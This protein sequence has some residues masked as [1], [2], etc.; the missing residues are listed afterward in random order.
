MATSTSI[1]SRT[2]YTLPDLPY[3]YNALEPT[4]S[5][6][7]MQI[8][9]SKHHATYVTNLNV[10]EE[11]LA[12]AHAKKD[13]SAIITLGSALKFNGGGHLNHSIFWQNLSPKGGGE[14]SGKRLKEH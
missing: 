11:K 14:P 6:E 8:H 2:K 13:V 1:S 12:E 9:H 4:I 3:D 10:A 7:I 5:A